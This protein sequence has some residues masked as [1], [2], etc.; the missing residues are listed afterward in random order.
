MT[1]YEFLYK[2]LDKLDSIPV[3]EWRRV[4]YGMGVYV[5]KLNDKFRAKIY[6]RYVEMEG[7]DLL[8]KEKTI[9][10]V[11]TDFLDVLQTIEA[12]SADCGSPDGQVQ[13]IN[14]RL[15]RLY[16]KLETDK[17]ITTEEWSDREAI[18]SDLER[19]VEDSK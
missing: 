17:S 16:K 19:F 10:I 8:A 6:H 3:Q 15:N 9:E 11:H 7:K 5:A 18:M 1:S 12:D 2:L 14:D 13:G 4:N